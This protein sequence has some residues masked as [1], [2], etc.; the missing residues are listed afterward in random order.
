M[1]YKVVCFNEECKKEF[2]IDID[3]PPDNVLYNI[4]TIQPLIIMEDCP[5]CHKMNTFV[6]Y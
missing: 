4:L 6:I 2:E 5:Y 1:K 3:T